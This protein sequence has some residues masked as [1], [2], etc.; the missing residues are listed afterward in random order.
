MFSPMAAFL[1]DQLGIEVKLIV[2]K[3]F[4]SF[5]SDVKQNK[6]DLVHFNQYHY[7]VAH[8]YFGYKVI[9][10]NE[11]DGKSTISGSIIVRKDSGINTVADLKGK[12]IAFGGGPRAMQS[13]IVASWLLNK[14]GLTNQDYSKKFA[15]N[16]PN[17]IISA[18]RKQ[19]DAAG[20]GDA[21]LP[22]NAAKNRIDINQM[23]YLIR[24][25]PAPHLPWA[26][27]NQ[28]PLELSEKIQLILSNLHSTLSG[29]RIL[30]R[31][32]LTDLIVAK[33]SDYDSARKIIVDVYGADYSV[34][35]L[36]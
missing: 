17:A 29:Q 3:N 7:A 33:D 21:N 30:N 25:D 8:Q 26:T 12:T 14:E 35:K 5:W 32:L 2:R 10:M 36:Q 16:P 4:A 6:Y 23:R 20:S 18:F 19:V 11:E 1:S 24:S 22:M 9:L 13:Y 15:L 27:S 31:A 34:N 28:V